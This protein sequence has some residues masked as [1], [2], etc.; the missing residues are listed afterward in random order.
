MALLKGPFEGISGVQLTTSPHHV[1]A[2]N[3]IRILHGIYRKF[4]VQTIVLPRK[5]RILHSS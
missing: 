1:G 3:D 5:H 4:I 2:V